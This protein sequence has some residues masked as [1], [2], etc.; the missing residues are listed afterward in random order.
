V[1]SYRVWAKMCPS[2]PMGVVCEEGDPERTSAKLFDV[3]AVALL[4]RTDY[5]GQ[6]KLAPMRVTVNATGFTNEDP[7]GNV[8]RVAI[9]WKD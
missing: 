9:D 4:S 6:L 2:D 5:A 3:Q 7:A 8:M 1:E